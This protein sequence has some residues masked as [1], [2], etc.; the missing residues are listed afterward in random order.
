MSN[1][2]V[3][4]KLLVKGNSVVLPL[5]EPSGYREVLGELPKN[6]TALTELGRPSDV[7]QL[8]LTSRSEMVT[9]LNGL[10]SSLKP[11]GLLWLT[12]PRA[13][14]GIKADVNRDIIRDYAESNGYK[15]VA[16][17]SLDDTWSALRLKAA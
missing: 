6:V 5:N 7:I 11:K 12:Y 4:E 3:A 14:S 17:I 10:K 9:R 16:M 13:A 15:A 1:K 2:S 8:F